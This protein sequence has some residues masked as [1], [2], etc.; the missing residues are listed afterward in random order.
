MDG[1]SESTSGRYAGD[2]PPEPLFDAF[3]RMRQPA[4]GRMRDVA[5]D[6]PNEGAPQPTV[7]ACWDGTMSDGPKP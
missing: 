3:I 1:A 5:D 2:L 6:G 4:V 7:G